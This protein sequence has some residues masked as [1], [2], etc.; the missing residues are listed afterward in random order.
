MDDI[1]PAI[2][3]YN[4]LVGLGAYDA[5]CDLLSDRIFHAMMFRIGSTRQLAELLE[6]LVSSDRRDLT[7][8]T[9]RELQTF[10]LRNL[11]QVYHR[12]GKIREAIEYY[13]YHQNIETYSS[14]LGDSLDKMS[15]ALRL[16]G[17]ILEAEISAKKAFLRAHEPDSRYDHAILWR[18]GLALAVRGVEGL[19]LSILTKA[20]D[21]LREYPHLL[22]GS[23]AFLA[24]RAI[25]VND[26]EYALIAANEAWD[27]AYH[28]DFERDFPRAARL[29]GLA[30]LTKLDLHSFAGERLLEAV[31]RARKLNLLEDELPAL[32]GLADLERRRGNLQFAREYLIGTWEVCERAPY[33]LFHADA[34]NV[35]A[36]IERDAGNKDKAVEAATKAYEL[37]WCDG[38]SEDG[39]QC[40]AYW[41]GLQKAKKH[42]EE[43]GAPIPQLPYFDESKHEPLPDI[44]WDKLLKG[45]D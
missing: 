20:K 2:E 39:K 41:W 1:A 35:L 33:P 42:L 10:V 24:Q 27:L 3:L 26:N 28:K 36:Q 34:L 23:L 40:Y 16:S 13:R 6:M 18:L 38:I 7:K 4:A 25:W 5:A 22:G 17:K 44:D 12:M 15:D 19:S 32:I 43:L 14:R 21:S 29:Q 31:V 30:A 9:D 8:L 37:A 11:A 45:D